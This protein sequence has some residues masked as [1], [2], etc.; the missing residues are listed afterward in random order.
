MGLRR[1]PLGGS[2]KPLELLMNVLGGLLGS[3]S[4]FFGPMLASWGAPGISSGLF[5]ASRSTTKA[6]LINSGTL[7]SFVCSFLAA[8]DG[9]QSVLGPFVARFGCSRLPF[10]GL[11][12]P[13]TGF[14]PSKLTF[15][16]SR[17][18]FYFTVYM[19]YNII[20]CFSSS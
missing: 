19:N 13:S 9:L 3:S 4:S 11:W 16:A 12:H 1:V 2:W 6:F 10:G 5:G 15:K 17:A 7:L 14:S 8:E 18:Y 20:Q